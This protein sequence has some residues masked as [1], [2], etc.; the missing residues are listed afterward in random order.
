MNRVQAGGID[1][2]VV[3][4]GK[5]GLPPLALLHGFA[6]SHRTW[7]K[8][9]GRLSQRFE[10]LLIDLPGHG[11]TPLPKRKVFSLTELG[12]ALTALLAELS[13]GPV[14]LCG[15]SMGGRAA[16]HAA[17]QQP[18]KIQA[19]ILIGASPGIENPFERTARQETDE[20]LAADVRARG[21]RWFAD[22]WEQLPLFE[23]QKSLPSDIRESIRR[24]R[25]SC[26]PQGLAF[27]LENFS[28]GRQDYLLPELISLKCPLLLV[29]GELD[30]KFRQS[31][32]RI[33]RSAASAPVCRFEV[34]GAG[35]AVHLESPDAVCDA[36][37]HFGKF[38]SE[39][40]L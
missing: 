8:L 2:H 13:D 10:L 5:R 27:C 22:Y 18:G 11:E 20:R 23:S 33:T 31:N 35:H 4:Q 32:A 1:W 16:I 40:N 24:E 36:L 38:I 28:V 37:I 25:L 12:T 7:E 34:C 21:V 39:G 30:R 17:L 9:T 6:G 26:D 19:L 3:R 15:Y 29:A 14:F